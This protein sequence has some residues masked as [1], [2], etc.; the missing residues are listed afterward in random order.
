[1]GSEEHQTDW[2]DPLLSL[3]QRLCLGH[4]CEFLGLHALLMCVLSVPVHLELVPFRDFVSVHALRLSISPTGSSA[5]VLVSKRNKH[6]P[7]PS[8]LPLFPSSAPPLS[9][10][11]V[12]YSPFPSPS[13]SSPSLDVP[14]IRGQSQSLAPGELLCNLFL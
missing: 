7:S 1:M 12:L 9:H 3:P 4:L 14:P 2:Q 13:S 11:S 6:S 5:S 8:P 10:S